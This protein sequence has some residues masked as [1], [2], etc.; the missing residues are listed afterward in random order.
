MNIIHRL[1]RLGKNWTWNPWFDVL[2]QWFSH[3]NRNHWE[4]TQTD[5]WKA[6]REWGT[7]M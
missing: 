7:P 4:A 1:L 6:R 2:P 3:Q 5:E